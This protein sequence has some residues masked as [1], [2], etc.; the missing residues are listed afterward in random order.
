MLSLKNEINNLDAYADLIESSFTKKKT[1]TSKEE[2][3][4]K[5]I[6]K[7]YTL[8]NSFLYKKSFFD[9]LF[10]YPSIASIQLKARKDGGYAK[11]LQ[12]L[13]LVELAKFVKR[14]TPASVCELGSGTTSALL[15][16]LCPKKV[17]VFEENEYW[18]KRTLANM[19]DLAADITMRR[20]DR[21]IETKDDEAVCYYDMDH[22]QYYDFVYVDGPY[23]EP[24]PEMKDLKIKDPT[25]SMP[26]I[27]V[28]LFWENNV[29]PRVILIDSRR[30][31]VRR[32]I[33]QGRRHY[34][35]YLK[36][37][38]LIRSQIPIA[39]NGLYHTVMIRKA[40][41]PAHA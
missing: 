5:C 19:G 41:T 36:S 20:S 23:A 29:F 33:A 38:L 15:A 30:A 21:I 16:K 11:S 17:T 13:R 28:E 1:L 9:L 6:Y 14:F 37:D 22:T 18:M 8:R 40:S 25:G 24:P 7:Y 26:N 2:L 35:I 4:F 10:A 34:D 12:W 39:T 31:S 27:D 32:L 3:R